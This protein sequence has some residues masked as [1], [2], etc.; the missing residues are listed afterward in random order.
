MN[1]I[2]AIFNTADCCSLIYLLWIVGS[3]RASRL[4]ATLS[5]LNNE[6]TICWKEGVGFRSEIGTSRKAECL[7]LLVR[8][9]DE[10]LVSI[11]EVSDPT[12]IMSEPTMSS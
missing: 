10:E 1:R 7:P 8:S 2:I 4:E 11:I 12:M 3:E 6:H 5:V 9:K